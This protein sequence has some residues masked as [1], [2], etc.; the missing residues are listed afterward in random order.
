MSSVSLIRWSGMANMVAGLL[1][2]LFALLHP[3]TLTTSAVLQ[4][5][6]VAEHTL[7]VA[8]MS[9]T[10]LG[11]V[12]IQARHAQQAGRLGWIGFALALIG[13]AY[14]VGDLRFDAYLFPIIAQEAPELAAIP[15]P[16]FTEGTAVIIPLTEI[17]FFGLGFVLL[18]LAIMRMSHWPRWSGLLLVVGAPLFIVGPPISWAVFSLGAVL[19]GGGLS[20]LGYVL[21]SKP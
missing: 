8:A 19:L 5:P 13:T 15:G 6:W 14:L 21:W 20:W 10:L 11:L 16:L 4:T 3:A 12:G 18:G 17:F 9:L 2:A 7:G 1:T